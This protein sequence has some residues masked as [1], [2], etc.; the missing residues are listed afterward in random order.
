MYMALHVTNEQLEK[1]VRELA[2]LAGESVTEAIGKAVSE[3]I[4]RIKPATSAEPI[5]SF[6]K[7]MEI[8]RSQPSAHQ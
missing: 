7:M 6:E 2:G 4:A 1:T 5:P 8:I 3:R